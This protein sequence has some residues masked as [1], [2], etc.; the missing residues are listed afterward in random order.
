MK[1]LLIVLFTMEQLRQILIINEPRNPLTAR[2]VAINFVFNTLLILG[3]V[4]S[5]K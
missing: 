1:A 5:F 2:D 3:I 4:R